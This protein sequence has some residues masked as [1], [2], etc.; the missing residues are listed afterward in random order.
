MEVGKIEQLTQ[1][2]VFGAYTK[3]NDKEAFFP[4]PE[5]AKWVADED[6]KA[7]DFYSSFTELQQ[8]IHNLAKEKGWYDEKREDG[9]LLALIHGEVSEV[10]EALRDGNP[11]DKKFPEYT[12]SEIEMADIVIRCM[13]MS[14][15]KGW[16][17]AGAILAKHE[18]N[19][20]R[21]IRHGGKKF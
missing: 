5:G 14:A 20:S 19:K 18:Y 12:E 17:L 11:K 10:M 8:D 9:T 16:N 7:F 2:Q 1:T 3:D 6:M 15:S 13:D 21:P 4:L